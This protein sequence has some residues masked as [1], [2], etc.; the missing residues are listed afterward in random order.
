MNWVILSLAV[1]VIGIWFNQWVISALGVILL[2]LSAT[3]VSTENPAKTEIKHKLIQAPVDAWDTSEEDMATF[4]GVEHGMPMQLGT[5]ILGPITPKIAENIGE[6]PAGVLRNF[7]PFRT[8]GES[9]AI[10]RMLAG[11][12]L[13]I[14][15]WVFPKTFEAKFRGKLKDSDKKTFVFGDEEE[16]KKALEEKDKDKKK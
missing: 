14:D 3:K 11:M 1:I 6:L 16:A 12:V 2:I 13:P 9:S 7:L 5:D 10:Q 8:Y 4:L 15:N